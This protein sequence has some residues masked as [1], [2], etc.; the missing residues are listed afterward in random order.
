[1]PA[2]GAHTLSAS[3]CCFAPACPGGRCIH[4]G[5]GSSPADA[6]LRDVGRLMATDRLQPHCS[7]GI[8]RDGRG[9][10]SGWSLISDLDVTRARIPGGADEIRQSAGARAP[11]RRQARPRD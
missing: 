9:E 11:R 4:T 3:Y 2:A 1:V 5:I 8:S 6:S 7:D 10:R